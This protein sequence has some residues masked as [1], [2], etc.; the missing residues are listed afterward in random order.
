MRNKPGKL[1]HS[2]KSW[3]FTPGTKADR[4]GRAAESHADALII[5]LED[6]VAPSAKKDARAMA[7]KYL[8]GFSF[9]PFP[10]ALR[11]NAPTTRVGLDDLQSLLGSSA[12]P[13]YLILPKSESAGVIALVSSLLRQSGKS[14]EIIALIETAR[15]WRIWK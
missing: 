13:D 11:I 3:L 9:G 4:F 1:I 5:D 10:C 8:E 14:T 2:L 12:E 7:L 15:G 6:A